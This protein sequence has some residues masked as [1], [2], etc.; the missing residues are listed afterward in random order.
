MWGHDIN[1]LILL[2]LHKI[3]EN[4]SGK[5]KDDKPH[6]MG[7]PAVIFAWLLAFIFFGIGTYYLIQT[8]H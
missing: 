6:F 1:A 8:I 7:I 2:N 5:A 4:E 3:Y